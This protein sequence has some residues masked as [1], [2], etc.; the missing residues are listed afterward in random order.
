MERPE[1]RKTIE[2]GNLLRIEMLI[3]LACLTFLS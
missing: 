1:I 2:Y 3:L